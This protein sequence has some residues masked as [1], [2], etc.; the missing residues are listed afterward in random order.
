[1]INNQIHETLA[2]EIIK[3]G[4]IN[5]IDKSEQDTQNIISIIN[6]KSKDYQHQDFKILE[7]DT[8]PMGYWPY[9]IGIKPQLIKQWITYHREDNISFDSLL[10]KHPKIK[11]Y[12]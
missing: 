1:M 8:N 2:D 7:L 9:L 11:L 4:M 6:K 10:K 12:I 5:G 3:Q